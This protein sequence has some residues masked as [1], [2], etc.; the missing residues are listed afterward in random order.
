MKKT[1]FIGVAVLMSSLGVIGSAVADPD[2]S[3]NLRG[4]GGRT[5]LVEVEV[6]ASLVPE[7]PV[8][9]VFPNCYTF[10]NGGNWIDPGFPVPGTW[11]QHSVGSATPY[12]AFA[13]AGGLVIVQEGSVT[14]ALGG[15]NLQ[16]HAY[17]TVLLGE[18]KLAEF[19]SVGEEVESCP[20]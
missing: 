12:T 13:D 8:G 9:T 20:L 1:I 14:P 6:V 4:M 3:Q 19:V 5:F 18:V 2:G 16:I 7:L 17:S 10:E 11:M 15:G